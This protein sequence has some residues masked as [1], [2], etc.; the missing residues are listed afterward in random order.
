MSKDYLVFGAPNIGDEEINAVVST[1]KSGWI[2]TGPRVSEFE[3][4]FKDYVGGK[5]AV[6]VSSCTSA[7][8]LSMIAIGLKSGD[9]V[10]VPA[11]TFAATANAVIHA[12]GTPIFADVHID[13]MVLTESEIR[14]KITN[15]TKA[16]IPVHFAGYPCDLDMI[17]K[18]A[19]EFGLAVIQDCAH[20]IETEFKG[21]KVGSYPGI[22][23]F[24]FYVT[25]NITCSEGGMIITDSEEIANKLKVLALH[26]MSKD[27]WKRFSDSGYKHYDVVVSGFKYNMT[28]IQAS[29]GL[30]QL[31]KIELFYQKRK[32]IW[33]YYQT[34][35][36]SLPV[37]TPMMVEDQLGKHAL[38]L[39]PIL[40]ESNKNSL[41]RDK[42][43]NFLHERNIGTGVHYT[44]LHLHSV[45]KS[46][47][48]LESIDFP[49]SK[50]ISDRTLSLP[51]SS[52][53]T[54]DDAKFVAD[55]LKELF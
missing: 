41:T 45:F 24:S 12:G 40:I 14:R 32:L 38:H 47:Y 33:D 4:S 37:K 19:D 51:L 5:Y 7:L 39:F 26:G 27:A 22:S 53:M 55:N 34:E 42:V 36:A 52:K 10:I 54:V 44:S 21:K 20:A 18:I 8:H 31:N 43:I 11:M 9:E 35:L 30:V 16:I 46:K 49:N 25:K 1:L 23:C 29:L 3:N 50:Y 15:K 13:S 48:N 6:A 17:F 2:G 28:D